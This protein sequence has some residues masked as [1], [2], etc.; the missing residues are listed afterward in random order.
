MD[1]NIFEFRLQGRRDMF[2]D[3][4]GLELNKN[5]CDFQIML[6]FQKYRERSWDLE[7]T[8]VRP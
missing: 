5:F 4:F 3:S 1:D 2:L 7:K 8:S 6:S